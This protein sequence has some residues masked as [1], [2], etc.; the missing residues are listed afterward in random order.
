MRDSLR[1]FEW[2]KALVEPEVILAQ[3]NDLMVHF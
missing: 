1:T 3:V 2:E